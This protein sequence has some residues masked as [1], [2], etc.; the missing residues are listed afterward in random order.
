MKIKYTVNIDSFSELSDNVIELNCSYNK[1]SFLPVLPKTLK[2]LVC[3]NN[4]LT[5][6]PELPKSLEYL[7]CNDNKL[8][9]RD[10][11]GITSLPEL[12]N[13]LIGLW[14][15][16][17]NIKVLPE[18]P[19]NLELLVCYNNPLECLIPYKYLRFQNSNWLESYYYP[20]IHSYEG[21]KKILDRINQGLND[22][23]QIKELQLQ[24][25]IHPKIKQEFEYLI[26]GCE[27]NLI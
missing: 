14:C 21:Q 16:N 22:A 27:L 3:C 11:A 23:T 19:N 8:S 20:M 26:N 15:Y 9:L 10:P 6:L 18:I 2:R 13:G 1:L 4:N 25:T 12:P 17:N 24:T 7:Y 5:S